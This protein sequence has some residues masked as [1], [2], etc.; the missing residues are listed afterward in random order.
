MAARSILTPP[1][2]IRVATPANTAP[3]IA[4][5]NAAFAIETF[6]G[7]S[8]TDEERMAQMM[9]KGEFLL[10]E[11]AAGRLVAVVYTERRG[12]R[13]YFG[14][15]AVDVGRQGT[16]LG[17]IMVEAAEDHCR[18]QGCKFMD[19]TVLSLR[20]ELLPFYRKLGYT[21]IGTEEFHPSRPLRDGV[22]C[23]CIVMSKALSTTRRGVSAAL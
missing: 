11:D 16:G 10:A 3:V 9:Q 22:E 5:V 4:V 1:V 12:D 7:G 6:L 18:R 17:R 8:R 14:M 23:H 20:P 21:E 2:R 13:G 19:I 15:L